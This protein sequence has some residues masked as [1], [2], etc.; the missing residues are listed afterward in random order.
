MDGPE[1]LTAGEAWQKAIQSCREKLVLA[2]PDWM[3]LEDLGCN[4]GTTDQEHQLKAVRE[5][6]ERIKIQETAVEEQAAKNEKLYRYLGMA[7]GTLAVL[8]FY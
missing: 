6:I 8:L 5:G 7:A 2:G 4:L 1:G 3:I